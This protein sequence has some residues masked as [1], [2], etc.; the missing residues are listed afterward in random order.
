MAQ[1]TEKPALPESD[2]PRKR[3]VCGAAPMTYGG[4]QA[5]GRIGAAAAGQPQPQH[6]IQAPSAT[7]TTAHG[8]TRSLTHKVRPGIEP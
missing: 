4:S 3:G 5:R 1:G 6:Q 7:Y 8:N 2:P